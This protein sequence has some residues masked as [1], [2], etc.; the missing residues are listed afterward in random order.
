MNTLAL[1]EVDTHSLKTV[2][3]VTADG[4]LVV[5]VNGGLDGDTT[6]LGRVLRYRCETVA[7]DRLG[8]RSVGM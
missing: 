8:I 5:D 2:T 3:D 1:V 7:A 4:E 6:I